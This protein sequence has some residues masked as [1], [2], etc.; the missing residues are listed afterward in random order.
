MIKLCDS[1]L[2]SATEDGAPEDIA[3]EL[4]LIMGLD[5]PDHICDQRETPDED[6][7]CACACYSYK[8]KTNQV[9][10]KFYGNTEALPEGI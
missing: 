10:I 7:H 9:R 1:C 3:P 2:D 6:I 4:M 8:K 5:M